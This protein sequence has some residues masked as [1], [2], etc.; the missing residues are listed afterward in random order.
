MKPKRK[1]QPRR[2][3]D[4]SKWW[5]LLAGLR[6]SHAAKNRTR[7]LSRRMLGPVAGLND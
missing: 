4:V 5:K 1:Q 2:Q 6:A 3:G 7:R